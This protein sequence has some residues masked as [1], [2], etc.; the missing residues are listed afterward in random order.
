MRKPEPQ[1]RNL[2]VYLLAVIL[3]LMLTFGGGIWLVSK[4]FDARL[5]EISVRLTSQTGQIRA[6]L[7]YLR[8]E[9]DQI[10]RKL[11]AL[12]GAKPGAPGTGGAGAAAPPA[13]K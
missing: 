5:D 1:P 3:L 9:L 2:D 8:K 7:F 10:S 6:E 11:D 13:R 4:G 12:A